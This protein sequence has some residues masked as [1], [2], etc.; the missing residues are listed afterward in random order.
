MALELGPR[1]IRTNAIAPGSIMTEGTKQLFYGEK[2]ASSTPKTQAFMQHIPLGAP[3][4]PRRDR[5]SGAVPV[6]AGGKLHQW[7][8]P[9]RRRRL[10]GG[11]HDVRS[12][13]PISIGSERRLPA[14]VWYPAL[15][16][17]SLNGSSGR[18]R[19]A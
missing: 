15:G 6:G 3:G 2:R 10:D 18:R 16:A 19:P 1:G 12:R 9:H 8:D 17:I 11:L 14:A 13:K 7:P 4:N 5:R